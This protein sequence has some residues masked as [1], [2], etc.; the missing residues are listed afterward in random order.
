MSTTVVAPSVSDAVPEKA[1]ASQQNAS[2]ADPVDK[3]AEVRRAKKKHKR[4]AHRAKLRR[5]H[6]KG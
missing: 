6:T 2:P 5:S 3:F 1:S 4:A